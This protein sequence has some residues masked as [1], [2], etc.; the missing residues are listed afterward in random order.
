MN[1]KFVFSFEQYNSG[2]EAK[3]G[4]SDTNTLSVFYDLNIF[5]SCKEKY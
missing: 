5:F 2:N 1:F 4:G 3:A